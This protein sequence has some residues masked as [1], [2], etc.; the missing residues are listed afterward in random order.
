MVSAVAFISL[1]ICAA[2]IIVSYLPTSRPSILAR[3][4]PHLRLTL[5]IW[6]VVIVMLAIDFA[7]NAVVERSYPG[8]F[9]RLA[10]CDTAAIL[11][12]VGSMLV[13]EPTPRD[14]WALGFGVGCLGLMLMPSVSGH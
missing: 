13:S 4:L 7:I 12:S 1:P 11:L 6:A 5:R 3:P 8:L 10:V 9:V 2:W 14:L